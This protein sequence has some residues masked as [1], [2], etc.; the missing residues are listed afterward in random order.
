MN[1]KPIHALI[2]DD[3]EADRKLISRTLSKSIFTFDITESD[4]LE[5]GLESC[6]S[7]KFDFAF[8]DY[9]L[10]GQDGLDGISALKSI[11]KNIVIILLTGQKDEAI[12]FDAMKKGAHSYI[13]K[14]YLSVDTIEELIATSLVNNQD[15]S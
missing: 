4:S 3:D 7:H 11:Q 15:R 2:I 5:S 12:A 14:S 9:R 13:D 8:V 6:K 1:K 10:P